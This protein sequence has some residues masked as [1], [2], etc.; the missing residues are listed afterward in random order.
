M[1]QILTSPDKFAAVFTTTFPGAY[2][3]VTSQDV[4][5]MTEC[6]LIGKYGEYYYRTDLERVRAILQYEQMREKRSA[7]C[8]KEEEPQLP[9]SCK[10]CGRL[11]ITQSNGK[12]GRPREYCPG[13]ESSRSTERYRRWWKRRPG[14]KDLSRKG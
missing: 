13:C 2:R 14:K 6:G 11:L 8:I 9:P 5:D 10:M 12:K 7:R 3:S 4:R 1:I